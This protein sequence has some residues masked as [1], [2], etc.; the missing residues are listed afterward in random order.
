[1][2]PFP[3]QCLQPMSECVSAAPLRARNRPRP[4][5]MVVQLFDAAVA[6]AAVEGSAGPVHEAA[7]AERLARA[8]L[9][10]GQVHVVARQLVFRQNAG[11]G[12]R[13]GVQGARDGKQGQEDQEHDAKRGLAAERD[14]QSHRGGPDQHKAE[15]QAD[16]VRAHEAASGPVALPVQNRGRAQRS[17]MRPQDGPSQLV[18]VVDHRGGMLS[19]RVCSPARSTRTHIFVQ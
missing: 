1:M 4:R 14:E 10:G 8:R 13:G 12:K 7:A 6:V 11:V 16:E 19:P 17:A 18:V 3:M 5:A 2:L 9:G 15:A